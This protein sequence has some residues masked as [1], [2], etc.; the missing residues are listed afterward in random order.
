[1][2]VEHIDHMSV[3]L[4]HPGYGLESVYSL[5]LEQYERMVTD[6]TISADDRVELLNGILVTKMGKTPPHSLAHYAI[7]YAIR[8]L[9][10]TAYWLRH[11]EPIRIAPNSEPE[12]DLSLV[13]GSPFDYA[14]RHPGA[15]AVALVAE[16]SDS[17]LPRDRGGKW[18]LYAGAGIPS[19]WI[20]NLV[21]RQLEVYSEPSA[22]GY[23]RRDLFGPG[24]TIPLVIDGEELGVIDMNALLPPT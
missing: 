15:E 1:V 12:P 4:I 10:P 13:R 22:R 2:I 3:N 18:L 20:L 21:D 11:E 8:N 24:G 16:I 17:S 19:F 9:I 5:S 6:G 14:D 7:E 23:G